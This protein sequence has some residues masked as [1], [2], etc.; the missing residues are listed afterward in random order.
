MVGESTEVPAI[1]ERRQDTSSDPIYSSAK[2]SKPLKFTTCNCCMQV[3]LSFCKLNGP[4]ALLFGCN[5]NLLQVY[6]L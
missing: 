3:N 2:P 4:V 5:I 1:K 6:Y